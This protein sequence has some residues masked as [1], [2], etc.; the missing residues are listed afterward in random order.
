MPDDLWL[1]RLRR[2]E[3][4]VAILLALVSFVP[5][6]TRRGDGSGASAWTSPHFCWLAVLLCLAVVAGRSLARPPVDDRWAVTGIVVAVVIAGWGWL[7]E[8]A[9]PD[10]TAGDGSH[11]L[12]WV[13]Q[14]QG[15]DVGPVD[16][17]ACGY[18][19]GLFLMGLLLAAFIVA[20]RLRRAR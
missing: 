18:P 11:Q 9:Q 7:S 1:V 4:V 3:V 13:L 20:A 17:A 6:W 2:G 16:V 14:D 8:L 10:A 12:A 19:I 15:S 5:W